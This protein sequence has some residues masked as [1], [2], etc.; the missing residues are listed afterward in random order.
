MNW[1][2]AHLPQMAGAVLFCFILYM[3]LDQML[4]KK[5]SQD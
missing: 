1:I 2:T 3:L 4:N 5:N